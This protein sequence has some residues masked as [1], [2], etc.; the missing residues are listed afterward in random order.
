MTTM[1]AQK[2]FGESIGMSKYEEWHMRNGITMS[3]LNAMSEAERK[4]YV[5]R[6]KLWK[7]PDYEAMIENGADP[8]VTFRKKLLRDSVRPLPADQS[9]QGVNDFIAFVSEMMDMAD[10]VDAKA[11][12]DILLD[13]RYLAQN[14]GRLSV[15]GKNNAPLLLNVTALN[16]FLQ[17]DKI[18]ER[19]MKDA[20]FGVPKEE[21]VPKG[22]CVY[23]Y[24]EIGG[25]NF[26]AVGKKNGRY[27]YTIQDKFPSEEDALTFAKEHAKAQKKK[28]KSNYNMPVLADLKR[29]GPDNHILFVTEDQF[30]SDL[31]MRGGEYGMYV[32][33]KERE[34]HLN[35]SYDALCDMADVLKIPHDHISM[36]NRI[37]IAYGARGRSAACAHYEPLREVVNLTR[38]NGAGSLGHEMMHAI[39]DILGKNLG[40]GGA[41]TENEGNAPESFKRLVDAML[42]R[43]ETDEEMAKRMQE[44]KESL[45]KRM[46]GN[47]RGVE[48]TL[49][50]LIPDD[51]LTKE[52]KQRKEALIRAYFDS[53]EQPLWGEEYAPVQALS[54]LCKDV[55]GKAFNSAD[56]NFLTRLKRY[57]LAGTEPDTSRH[58]VHSDF[59]TNSLDMDN[60]YKAAGNGYWASRIELFA[61]AGACYLHDKLAEEGRRNDY[62]CGHSEG[63]FVPDT[64]RQAIPVG[65]E[66]K[67]INA[68]FDAFFEDMRNTGNM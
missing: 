54:I 15:T 34:G 47:V 12:R 43:P 63:Y 45:E 21:K 66:R 38:K 18:V 22:Y 55:T 19:L 44:E 23:R 2:T 61:R 56:K 48:T 8:I 24:I 13:H 67:R 6:D 29:V 11:P 35:E 37:S 65:E 64:K 36:G 16:K 53:K 59:Y 3:D 4:K 49:N 31:A 57:L 26:W 62:L 40:C 52:Q 50:I 46:R 58:S 17:T 20:Q 42:Y 5:T 1:T 60:S 51:K 33:D 32:T 41:L 39:D 68:C 28:A 9:A 30:L 14:Y 10:E 27:R 7:K 25:K